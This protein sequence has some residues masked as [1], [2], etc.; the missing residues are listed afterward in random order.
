MNIIKK[1]AVFLWLVIGCLCG[2]TQAEIVKINNLPVGRKFYINDQGEIYTHHSNSSLK[3]YAA[4]G[5]ELFIAGRAG[6]GPGDIKR[7]GWFDINPKDSLIYVTE[8]MNGNR[9]ITRFSSTTGKYVDLWPVQLDWLKWE[10]FPIIQFDQ[11]GNAY[12]QLENVIW[13]MYK[14]FRIGTIES[15]LVKFSATGKKIKDVYHFS[16][17]FMAD[18]DGKGNITIPYNN[19]VS[20]MIVKNFLYIR[21]SSKDKIDIYDLNGQYIKGLKLPFKREK[22]TDEDLDIWE[23]GMREDPEFRQ[24][25]AQGWFDI[26]FWRNNLPF[27][28]YKNISGY[29]MYSDE[30]GNI[31]S[32]KASYNEDETA[33]IWAKIDPVSGKTEL[34]TISKKYHLIGIKNNNFYF[35]QQLEDSEDEDVDYVVL[36]VSADS[37]KQL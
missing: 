27:P 7:I 4:D 12:I 9:R 25:I 11:Q 16:S 14:S 8:L 31:Y 10:S 29:K 36:K 22:L 34:L 5:K 24:G 20:W 26:K 33:N 19:N 3:K 23:K 13:S 2:L 35:Y 32:Q 15:Y 6:E 21:E 17:K 18:Q 28:E 37:L 1:L 30:K